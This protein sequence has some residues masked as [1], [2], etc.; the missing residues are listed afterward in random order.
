MSEYVLV[1]ERAED[2][3]WGRIRSGPPAS[4]ALGESHE[5]V[6]SRIQEAVDAYARG[7]ADLGRPRPT[8]PNSNRGQGNNRSGLTAA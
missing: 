4:L 6:A 3:G 7:Q 5:E 8:T 2:S 1:F